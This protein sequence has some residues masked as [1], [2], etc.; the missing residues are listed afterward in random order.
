MNKYLRISIPFI[1]ACLMLGT[2]I[3]LVRASNRADA[4]T[5]T[6]NP[7]AAILVTTLEDELNTDGD[8]SLRE[9]ITAAN[10]NTPVDN[11][12]TGD[13]VITDTITF[14]VSGTIILNEQVVVS[15]THPLVIDGGDVITLQGSGWT[16]I[17]QVK[18]EANLNV[19]NLTFYAGY[20]GEGGGALY[21]QGTI[22]II[23]CTFS[24]NGCSGTGGGLFNIGTAHI[25]HSTFLE[26]EGHPGGG[27]GNSG[28]MSIQDSLFYLNRGEGGGIWNGG[29]LAVQESRF[30][31]NAVEWY[32]GGIHN[33]YGAM[34]VI[35]DT[36]FVDNFAA[37][38]AGLYNGGTMTIRGTTFSLNSG[39]N[40]SGIYNE[41][42][43]S[44]QNT[45]IS[46]NTAN[47]NGG[48]IYNWG[49]IIMSS[50]TL[51]GNTGVHGGGGIDNY[52]WGGGVILNNSIVA[53]SPIG[54]D[55]AG[56]IIDGGY[57]IDTDGTCDLDPTNG[58]LPNTDPLLGPLQ[59]NGGP[60]W[61]HALL[62]DSPAIDAGEDAQ[63]PSTDQ[64]GVPRPQDGDHDGLAV[65]DIG[66]FEREHVLVPPSL[67]TISGPSEGV[68]GRVTYFTATVEPISTTLPLTYVWNASWHPPITETRGL[69]DT[70]G[71]GWEL[72]GMQYITV[73]VSNLAG[74]VMDTHTITITAPMYEIYLPLVTKSSEAPLSPGFPPPGTGLLLGLVIVGMVGWWK[75]RN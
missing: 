24:M 62:P 65:C 11:C 44:L 37:Y 52:H 28:M 67:V 57:N 19:S 1:L 55:C 2:T 51:S 73:T 14:E 40:G 33:N 32:G 4:A 64:R 16:R 21:N 9:A 36:T 71:W 10:D 41:G 63:C 54:D 53:N 26:N 23:N 31:G 49:E 13:A 35:S 48:G 39:Y 72:P 75:K 61:T 6:T 45:T 12:G 42:S 66:S 70:V 59:D 7:E 29:T 58:S 17:M 46:N 22:N 56:I 8:C 27:L 68:L 3:F 60:T 50:T 69:T 15:D 5:Y 30:E 47:W 34:M 25:T 38:G 20:D 43:L 18:P 74:S